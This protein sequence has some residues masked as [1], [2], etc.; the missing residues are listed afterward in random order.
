MEEINYKSPS[1][2]NYAKD[3][4]EKPTLTKAEEMTFPVEAIK[5]FSLES[6]VSCRQ[7]S[8]CHGCR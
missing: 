5:N 8:G 2:E 4:Y 6:K 1:S 7:C 3:E